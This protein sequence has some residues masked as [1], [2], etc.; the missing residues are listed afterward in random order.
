MPSASKG[1]PAV[2]NPTP[3]V[4][5]KFIAILDQNTTRSND[6]IKKILTKEGIFVDFRSRVVRTLLKT[7]PTG[8]KREQVLNFL[9]KNPKLT[10]FSDVVVA[11]NNAGLPV[12]RVQTTKSSKQPNGADISAASSDSLMPSQIEEMARA[13]RKVG[14]LRRARAALSFLQNLQLSDD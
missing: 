10:K 14:G 2:K 7:R 11:L 1:P 13:V 12:E 8:K 4:M 5:E 9:K 6:E 3:I